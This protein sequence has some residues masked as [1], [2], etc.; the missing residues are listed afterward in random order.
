MVATAPT[1]GSPNTPTP[2]Q[3]LI[4]GLD[5]ETLSSLV[6]SITGRRRLFTASE[7]TKNEELVTQEGQARTMQ[8]HNLQLVEDDSKARE[9]C[10]KHGK[11]L[12]LNAP[13]VGAQAAPGSFKLRK[14]GVP[15]RA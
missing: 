9:F 12:S 3:S 8:A 4:R 15:L 11:G 14:L 7:L 1:A 2:F 5:F 10:L 13:P 6:D